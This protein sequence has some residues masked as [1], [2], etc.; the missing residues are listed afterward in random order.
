MERE[1][2]SPELSQRA[3]STH[4]D[5]SMLD[6]ELLSLCMK[7]MP[8]PGYASVNRIF[9]VLCCV[10][11]HNARRGTP[12]LTNAG[13]LLVA[14]LTLLQTSPLIR[15]QELGTS[16][17]SIWFNL[18]SLTLS[19]DRLVGPL[20]CFDHETITC[21]DADK[22]PYTWQA[23]L[24]MGNQTQSCIPLTSFYLA[25]TALSYK[26]LD[27]LGANTRRVTRRQPYVMWS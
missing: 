23:G 16:Y 2:G 7:L 10:D 17:S 20:E 15:R 18:R 22:A 3:L 25:S 8:L 11:V 24:C 9:I 14:V 13:N 5:R 6:F 27:P 4:N 19:Y 1:I 26:A 12:S 21:S